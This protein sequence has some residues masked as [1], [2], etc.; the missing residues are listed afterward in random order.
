MHDAKQQKKLE[1]KI[2]EL[3]QKKACIAQLRKEKSK[4][5]NEMEI[6]LDLEEEEKRDILDEITME[7]L[8]DMIKKKKE[9]KV[10]IQQE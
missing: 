4:E 6:Q 1:E 7:E 10:Q 8:Q 3:E 2:K 9:E 5:E